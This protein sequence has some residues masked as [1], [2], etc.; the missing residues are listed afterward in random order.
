MEVEVEVEMVLESSKVGEHLDDALR[1]ELGVHLPEAEREQVAHEPRAGRRV[2]EEQRVLRDAPGHH[3]HQ[4]DARHPDQLHEL[5]TRRTY[6]LNVTRSAR[7]P[8]YLTT[9]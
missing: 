9:N 8:K 3:E 4:H 5:R 7:K 2:R 6:S 1:V